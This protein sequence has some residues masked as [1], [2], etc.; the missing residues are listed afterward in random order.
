M[1]CPTY[2]AYKD[3]GPGRV[4]NIRF[5]AMVILIIFNLFYW[6]GWIARQ[7]N[8]LSVKK[9]N[10]LKLSFLLGVG[11]LCVSGLVLSDKVQPITS[12]SALQSYRSGEA[13]LY[14]HIY[15]Q[16]LEILND[17]DVKDALLRDFP[18]KPYVLF[19]ADITYDPADWHNISVSRYYHK[20]SV[21]LMTHE[22]FELNLSK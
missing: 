17:P 4:E 2:Y 12:I 18:K 6:E 15:K 21:R 20:D 1:N 10:G 9:G 5:F 22:E 3:P 16:R 8:V 19:F 7:L 11:L 14:K 13:G